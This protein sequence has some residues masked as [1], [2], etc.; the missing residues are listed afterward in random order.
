MS[1]NSVDHLV[2]Y[3]FMLIV[4][5]QYHRDRAK[6]RV[7]RKKLLKTTEPWLFYKLLSIFKHEKVA[8]ERAAHI[9]I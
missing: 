7:F 6:H 4:E 8:L 5:K 1:G 2:L 3:N 9:L